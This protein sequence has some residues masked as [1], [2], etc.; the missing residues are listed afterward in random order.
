MTWTFERR[1]ACCLLLAAAGPVL[2]SEPAVDAADHLDA[3]W[4]PAAKEAAVRPAAVV[5]LPPAVYGSVASVGLMIALRYSRH[6]RWLT[7]R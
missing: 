3:D 7:L 4:L 5:P 1:I 6:R 2:A